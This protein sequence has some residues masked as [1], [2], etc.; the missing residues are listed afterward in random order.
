MATA[1]EVRKGITEE[2]QQELDTV[3]ER[4]RKARAI[5]CRPLGQRAP[6][7]SYPG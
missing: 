6:Q 2:Q 1:P 5:I 4:A 3:F 7:R